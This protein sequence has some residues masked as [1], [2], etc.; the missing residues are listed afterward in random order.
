MY[1]RDRYYR[2]VEEYV[3][4]LTG[5][6]EKDDDGFTQLMVAF[7]VFIAIMWASM[8]LLESLETDSF[9]L[10]LSVAVFLPAALIACA[11]LFFMNYNDDRKKERESYIKVLW[12]ITRLPRD[13]QCM[14]F[15]QVFANLIVRN[16]IDQETIESIRRLRVKCCNE[17]CSTSQNLDKLADYAAAVDEARV[18][19]GIE[20]TFDEEIAELRRE[21]ADI[22]STEKKLQREQRNETI[23]NI[24]NKVITRYPEL[25]KQMKLGS[26]KLELLERKYREIR[27]L[28][29][30]D[31]LYANRAQEVEEEFLRFVEG[32]FLL[33]T[34]STKRGGIKEAVKKLIYDESDVNSVM[35]DIYRNKPFLGLDLRP[36]DTGYSEHLTDV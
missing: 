29:P 14:E 28:S 32:Y 18:R 13:S 3:Q 19:W 5:Y 8:K 6:T 35:N 10:I 17:N 34:A 21:A 36:G 4:D 16:I 23:R 24:R 31:N 15:D 20:G 26:R 2:T 12:A 22:R 30:K 27:I 11:V 7:G 33:S 25:K 1:S 9:L